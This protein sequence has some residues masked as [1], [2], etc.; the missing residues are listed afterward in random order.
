MRNMEGL[1]FRFSL[2]GSREEVNRECKQRKHRAT[3]PNLLGNFSPSSTPFT[4]SLTPFPLAGAKMRLQSLAL[5][6]LA[7]LVSSVSATALTY[8]VEANEKACFYT[9]VDQM[10]SKVAFY[11]AVRHSRSHQL[12]NLNSDL[13]LSVCLLVGW[14]LVS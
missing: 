5:G 3:C 12:A 1:W 7:T 8:K 2:Y 9:N 14:A 11:F 4:S 13:F 10:N 6:L